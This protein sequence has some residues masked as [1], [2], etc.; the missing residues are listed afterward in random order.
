MLPG[1]VFKTLHH[2]AGGPALIPTGCSAALATS[3][4]TQG[5]DAQTSPSQIPL[6]ETQQAAVRD[7]PGTR[8]LPALAASSA[9]PW[10]KAW[11]DN[12][13]RGHDRDAAQILKF[14][15]WSILTHRKTHASVSPSGAGS[16]CLLQGGE[17]E[18]TDYE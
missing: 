9:W 3:G 14:L 13:D 4:V 15:L 7:K 16:P 18:L 10:E 8:T 6:S 1:S 17:S 11:G 12:R 5:E 2:G